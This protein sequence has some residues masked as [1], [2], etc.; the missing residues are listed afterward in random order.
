MHVAAL[1]AALVPDDLLQLVQLV[2]VPVQAEDDL[3]VQQISQTPAKRR[4]AA[5]KS[6]SSSSNA[7]PDVAM[8]KRGGDATAATRMKRKSQSRSA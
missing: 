1:D 5:E 7:G 8:P 4:K 2:G 3:A 6:A